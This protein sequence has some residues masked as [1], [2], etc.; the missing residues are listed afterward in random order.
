E[1]KVELGKRLFFDPILSADR[2]IS[3]ASCHDP[4]RAFAD[5][6]PVSIGV[7]GRAGIRNSPSLVNVAYGRLFFWDGGALTLENQVLAPLEDHREMDADLAEILQRLREDPEYSRLFNAVFDEAPSIPTLT[8]AI[9][10]YERTLL[11]G[12]SR[13]DRFLDGQV[14]AMTAQEKDGM[15]LFEGAAGC[16]TCHR[17]FLLTTGEFV[18]NGLAFAAA[19]SGRA[20]IT[21]DSGDFARFK[22]PSLRNV[23][24]T[25]PYMHDGRL[26]TLEDVIAHYDAGGTGS[27]GQHEAIRPLHL[28]AA[29]REALIAFLMTLTDEVVYEGIP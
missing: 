9:A 5:P 8:R 4:E 27:R 1:R 21:L 7:E 20:R 3:C 17:G 26:A 19:D 16:A 22:V 29:E 18:N 11:S 23:A 2:T 13:Y 15:A 25:A 10:A 24:L 28:T 6:R 14:Y 12:G